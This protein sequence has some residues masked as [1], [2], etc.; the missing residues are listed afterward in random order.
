MGQQDT[1]EWRGR[2]QWDSEAELNGEAEAWNVSNGEASVR[3]V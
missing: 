3:E 1:A 2:G